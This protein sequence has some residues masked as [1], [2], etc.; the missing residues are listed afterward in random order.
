MI[1]FKKFLIESPIA[2]HGSPYDFD[3]F[4]LQHIGSGEGAAAYGWGLYFSSKKEVAEWYIG[5]KVGDAPVPWFYE[6]NG[7]KTKAGTPE[8]KAADLIYTMGLKKAKK[9]IS[10][11]LNDALNGEEWTK[12]NGLGYYKKMDE[13]AQNINQQR[14]VKKS[15]GKLY[16][17]DIIPSEDEFLHWNKSL[18]EQSEPIKKKLIPL[19]EKAHPKGILQDMGDEVKSIPLNDVLKNESY[20]FWNQSGEQIYGLA[21]H[22]FGSAKEASLYFASIGIAGTKYF[23]DSSNEL[24]YV[25]FDDSLVKIRKKK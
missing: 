16:H 22:I 9:F 11:M 19:F 6:I 1:S 5:K 21:K 8:Q 4:K 17:V 15:K 20:R 12:D 18:K 23:G 25:L 24:N 10:G 13:I 3:E 14:E 7:I 2:Y